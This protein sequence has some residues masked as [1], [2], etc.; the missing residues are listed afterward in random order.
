MTS[1]F[2]DKKLNSE[3]HDTNLF[4]NKNGQ[5]LT[6]DI[7]VYIQIHQLLLNIDTYF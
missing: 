5:K 7:T 2:N 3:K 6:L 4:I 1:T